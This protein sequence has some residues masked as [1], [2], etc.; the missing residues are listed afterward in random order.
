MRLWL[1]F[2][3]L[4]VHGV[5]AALPDKSGVSPQVISL[6]SGPGAVEGLGESFEPQLNT[7]SGHY[8]LPFKLPPGRAGF[9]PAAGLIYDSGNG[10]GSVGFGWRLTEQY[11]KRQ[12]DKGLPQYGNAA[13][14]DTYINESGEE[15]VRVQGGENDPIQHFRLKNEGEFKRYTYFKNDD[16]WQVTDRAGRSYFLGAR[17]DNTDVGA[18]IRHP[19]NG[20]SYAWY[21]TE[22]ADLNGNRI[23]YSYISNQA[24]VYCKSIEYGFSTYPSTN[25]HLVSFSY[26]TRPDVLSDY[27]PGFRLTTALRLKQISVKTGG[28]LVRQYRLAYRQ[29]SAISL[30]TRV[31][32]VGNDAASTLPP[33]EFRYTEPNLSPSGELKPLTGLTGAAILLKGENPDDAPGSAEII[34]FDGDSLPDFYQSHHFASPPNEY[35]VLYRNLGGGRFVRKDLSQTESLGLSIQAQNSFVKDINGDGLADVI[36]QTGS[37]A[38]DLGFRLNAGGQWAAGQT[39]FLLPA[40][41]TIDSVF[42]SA[43]VRSADL[44]FDKQIDTLRSF[45][46]NGPSGAGGVAFSAYLNHGDGS[47]EFIA[48]TSADVVKGVPNTFAAM[49]GALTLADMNGDRLLDLVWLKDA[50]NGGPKYWPAMGRGQFDD[51]QSGYSIPLTDGPDFGGDTALSAKLELA[52]L[53]DDGLADLYYVSGTQIRY[54][55][56]EGGMQFGKQAVIQLNG[57]FDPSE[58][59]YRLLDIDGDRLQD[60]VFYAR[61][62]PTPDYIPQGFW[63]V[64]LFRDNRD[65]LTDGIDND[66]DG[67]TDETDE[68][69]SGPNLL[70]SIGNGIGRTVSLFYDTQVWDMLRDRQQGVAWETVMPFPTAVLRQMDVHDG[71]NNYVTQYRYR[72]GY[73]DGSEKEFRGF[74]LA[75]KQEIGDASA[76]DLIT[77]FQFDTGKST[78][79]LKGKVLALTAQTA[80][81]EVF[82][83]ETYVWSTKLLMQGVGGDGRG[84]VFPIQQAKVRDVLEKGK[85]A[86]VQLKW[87]YVYDDYGNTTRI[88]EYGRLD[89]AW[90]DERITETSFS[91]AFPSGQAQWILDKPIEHS[92]SD[93]NGKLAARQR[94]YYDQ[95]TTLG[96][97]GRGNETRLEEWVDGN[98]YVISTRKDYDAFGNVTAIYD[99]LYDA[100]ARANGHYREID[101]DSVYHT[102]PVAERIYTDTLMLTT[103]ADYDFGFGAVKSSTDFNAFT[104]F[105]HYDAFGR[106][107]SIR[108]PPDTGSTVEYAYTLAHKLADGRIINWVDIKQRET[109]GGGTVDSRI[110]YDG[111]GRKVM[112]RA[113]GELPGQIVVSDTVRFNA[114]KQPWRQY[115]PYFEAGA[116]LDFNPPSFGNAFVEHRYDALSRE[117]KTVQPGG[118]FATRE[119]QPLTKLVRDEEQSN[120]ASPHFG[121]AMRYI[122]DGLQDDQGAGRLREVEEI[123]KIGDDGNPIASPVTWSTRYSYNLL[124]NLTGY[125]DAQ[126]NQKIIAYD[127]LGRKIFMNDPDR[128]QMRY[129]YDAAGNLLKTVD[130]KNQ[131]VRYAYDGVNRLSAEFYSAT[132]TQ[133]DVQYHYDTSAGKLPHGDYWLPNNPETIGQAILTGQDAQTSYDV[134]QDGQIDAADVVKAAL[135]Q[136]AAGNTLQ[137]ENVRGR[138]AWASD[139]SGE[140][141]TSYDERGRAKWTVKRIRDR[142]GQLHNFYTGMAYDS[143]DR[144]T[145][146]IYPDQTQASFQYNDRGLLEAI[147]GVIDA[148]DYN[149]AGQNLTLRLANGVATAYG[150]DARLRLKTLRS[151]RSR[152]ALPLQNYRY[153]YDAVSNIVQIEDLRSDAQLVAIGQE[154]GS[155]D[156]EAKRFNAAQSFQYDSLYRLT[157]AKN[158]AVYGMI[159]YRYD[160][161][162]NL[163][164]QNAALLQ[165]DAGVD[166]GA[167]NNGGNAG[168]WNRNGRNPGDAPGPHALT[169]TQKG[170]FGALGYDDN[171]NV[172]QE[173]GKTLSWDAKDRLTAMQSNNYRADYAYDYSDTRKLKR[174][175]DLTTGASRDSFYVDKF[176]E[177][178]D[179]KLIKYLYAGTRRIARSARTGGAFTPEAFY[180][181]D[182]LGSTHFALSENG[183]ALAQLVNYPYGRSRL[184]KQ[185][186]GASAGADYKFT[187]KETDV[188]SGL[189]YFEAR[190]FAG[191]LGVFSSPD[192]LVSGGN[193]DRHLQNPQVLSAYRYSLNRPLGYTDDTG[194]FPHI[195]AGAL[196]GAAV[197]V[198]MHVATTDNVTVASVV[199]EAAKGAITGAVTA[200]TLGAGTALSGLSI[201][202]SNLAAGMVGEGINQGLVSSFDGKEFSFSAVGVSGVTNMTLGWGGAKISNWMSGRLGN[203]IKT[204]EEIVWPPNRGFAGT[205]AQATLRPGAIVDRYGGS[206]GTFLAPEAT[207]FAMRS[208]PASSATKPLN[209]YKVLKP[210]EVDAGKVAPW[211][212]Q[213]GGGMQYDLPKTVQELIESG[214][215]EKIN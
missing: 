136:A 19:G 81:N 208:L 172:T 17:S 63:Y 73:Y 134:N 95:N 119:Y 161:I 5:F 18:R 197:S 176:S 214:H 16:R 183:S 64:R 196:I 128:G 177:V 170:S 140:E 169:A 132:G 126:N 152:D 112:T 205:P 67:L 22:A 201:A 92:V 133:A 211:F 215:L 68:G 130:A 182:H 100:N 210:I 180:L 144:I 107:R 156:V 191:A 80:A 143:M 198:A 203:A 23:V 193:I 87:E 91:A 30:L 162:G 52:D 2:C 11:V 77:R 82:Y 101:Y 38:E 62:Q 14:P 25:T 40:G 72:N 151:D 90:D 76:P 168:A 158:D 186:A 29:P 34:D 69:N 93:E 84:V 9:T 12:S 46:T 28:Q 110:F 213:P 195:A 50:T 99:P 157:Q 146:L 104:T 109:D 175:T 135:D 163:L 55:L 207:P 36:A 59:T 86:P 190:Y 85:A 159:A 105:Y 47:F 39:A 202:G 6:P 13:K 79:A 122:E 173:G 204:A 184:E 3:L 71:A 7:G 212:G 35:D 83:S 199:G 129:E 114:Q 58:A 42:K 149:P 192:P 33:A 127:G 4:V 209:V 78:E 26:E 75:E 178:R 44:D 102:F 117:I 49:G 179:G 31:T 32:V 131:T 53:N 125:T 8:A 200:A 189:Q 150:Y 61:S 106:L 43:E 138:L 41:E 139:L 66:Q 15:L 115:L 37:N 98:N 65:R 137:A 70:A 1:L 187:G 118:K 154:L 147:P 166:L 141:H 20:L 51:S 165:P 54:W 60:M 174:V 148:N 185:A 108:K 181:H 120:V 116:T 24:Q 194:E 27:R 97:I 121:A 48:Q 88:Y 123:V 57:Q 188:E 10:N 21:L 142:N 89:G 74:A 94:H 206:S 167:V 171:G 145:A 153:Q 155:G 113:E 45:F 111:L 56:N 160:R 103:Q 124:D 164:R 96:I